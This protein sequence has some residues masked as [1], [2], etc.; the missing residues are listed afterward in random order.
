M[1]IT[2][3]VRTAEDIMHVKGVLFF[4][5]INGDYTIGMNNLALQDKKIEIVPI[6]HDKYDYKS[7]N[8]LFFKKEWLYDI[9]EEEVIE[10]VNL[11]IKDV[12]IKSEALKSEALKLTINIYKSEHNEIILSLQACNFLIKKDWD[13]ID[14]KQYKFVKTVQLIGELNV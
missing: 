9:K 10:K 5:T 3:L 12:T 14:Y 11:E 6:H 7:G 8:H 2:A 4:N 1:K 13:F